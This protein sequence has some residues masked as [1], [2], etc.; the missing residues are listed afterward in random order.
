MI[1]LNELCDLTAKSGT[2]TAD[3]RQACA[4]P[5]S[6]ADMRPLPEPHEEFPFDSAWE[7]LFTGTSLP[8]EPGH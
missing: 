6:A 2:T 5:R 4:Q 1:T 7:A 3:L 8:E